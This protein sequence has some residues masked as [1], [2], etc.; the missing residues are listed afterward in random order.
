MAT[1]SGRA[2]SSSSSATAPRSSDVLGHRQWR[3]GLIGVAGEDLG[4]DDLR[5]SA[6]LGGQPAISEM[7]VD[8]RGLDRGM[9]GLGLDRFQGH[10]GLAEPGQTGV[11]Q[12]V[13][14]GM[15]QPGPAT[16]AGEDLIEPGCGQGTPAARLRTT[17]SRS[18][19]ASGGRSCSR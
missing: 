14:G 18:D 6:V 3:G 2:A 17:N 13:A 16:G 8:P 19:S 7:E 11:A 10:P 1:S 9:P 15:L 12:F 4:V 5:S